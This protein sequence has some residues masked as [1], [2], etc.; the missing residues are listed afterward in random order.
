MKKNAWL[1]IALAVLMAGCGRRYMMTRPDMHLAPALEQLPDKITVVTYVV[2]PELDLAEGGDGR[3]A[4]PAVLFCGDKA[5]NETKLLALN[6]AKFGVDKQFLTVIPKSLAEL[7]GCRLA[8]FD[9]GGK[10]IYNHKGEVRFLDSMFR[11]V[12]LK[13]YPDFLPEL[14]PDPSFIKELDT[15]SEEFQAIVKLYAD[16]RISELEIARKYIYIKFGSNFTSEQLDQLAKEDAIVRGFAYWLGRDWKFFVTIPFVGFDSTALAAGVAKVLTLP[17]IWGDDRLDRPGYM[18]HRLDAGDAA[19]MIL[20]GINEYGRPTA[21]TF[22]QPE[23]M[24]LP[25]KASIKGTACAAEEIY[26]YRAY[27]K[28]VQEYNSKIATENEK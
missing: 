8:V 24:P 26:T 27:N 25:A 11:K 7:A 4:W 28:C 1:L 3:F 23:D 13:K 5:D 12:D 10:R 16:F 17:S 20:R 2:N 6:L 15:S 22:V 19:K 9:H 18:E 21:A 14:G